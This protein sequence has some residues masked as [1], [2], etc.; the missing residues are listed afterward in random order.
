M[1]WSAG[2]KLRQSLDGLAR[3][4]AIELLVAGRALDLRAPLT[5]ASG[6]SAAL[7]A[8]RTVVPGPGPDAIV[9]EQIE[10]VVALVDSGAVLTA[11]ESAVGVLR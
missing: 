7:Q 8:L 3:V 2:L 6:T 9:S 11:V 5:P 1:G 10:A 4:L